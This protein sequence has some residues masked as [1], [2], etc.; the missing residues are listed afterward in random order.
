MRYIG[1]YIGRKPSVRR[2]KYQ[3]VAVGLVALGSSI[4]LAGAKPATNETCNESPSKVAI[5]AVQSTGRLI[6]VK[7]G[8]SDLADSD[9]ELERKLASA[10]DEVDDSYVSDD[11]YTEADGPDY[12]TE[13][14][15]QSQATDMTVRCMPRKTTRCAPYKARRHASFYNDKFNGRKTKSGFK[16]SNSCMTVA[17]PSLPSGTVLEVTNP[18]TGGSV[19]VTVADR[20]PFVCNKRTHRCRP[21]P[22]R[23]I[24]LT[25]RAFTALF[26]TIEKGVGEIDIAIC[27]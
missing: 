21:H 7:K 19:R 14:P 1:R 3:L 10:A 24:D 12:S 23:E 27:D 2:Y 9:K 16:F 20:G 4:A 17:H 22:T 18:A 15:D 5:A 26:G 11:G 6:S 25:K 13:S 8:E